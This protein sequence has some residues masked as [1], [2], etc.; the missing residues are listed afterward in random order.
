MSY[1]T[2]E[3]TARPSAEPVEVMALNNMMVIKTDPA[4]PKRCVA[5][6]GGTK[7]AL[8]SLAEIGS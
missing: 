3:E 6:A 4:L 2:S 8:A 7:P 1:T 5:T